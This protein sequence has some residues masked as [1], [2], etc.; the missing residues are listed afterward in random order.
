M[1]EICDKRVAV[2]NNLLSR[3]Y[4]GIRNREVSTKQLARLAWSRSCPRFFAVSCVNAPL[5]LMEGSGRMTIFL[6]GQF[7]PEAQAVIPV[8]DRGFMYG[9]GLV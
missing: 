3:R 2:A 6:N 9:D 1:C 8:N 7:V 5:Q 4:V